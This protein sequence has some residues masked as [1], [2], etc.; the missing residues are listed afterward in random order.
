MLFETELEWLI[1]TLWNKNTT[2]TPV[3]TF[4]IP[5]TVIFKQGKPDAWFF[6][7][8]EGHLLKKN[9]HNTTTEKI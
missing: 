7:S 3:Y 9:Y 6:R 1:Y 8:K 2:V 5:Q 4:A